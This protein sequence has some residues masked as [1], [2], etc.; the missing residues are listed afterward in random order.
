MLVVALNS[1]FIARNCEWS[2]G[3][4][5]TGRMVVVMVMKGR[6]YKGIERKGR[7]RV[8][9]FSLVRRAN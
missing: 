3:G 6:E 1:R 8:H 4:F 7:E 9:H 2:F 5:K